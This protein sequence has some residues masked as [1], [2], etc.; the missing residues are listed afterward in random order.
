MSNDIKIVRLSRTSRD[1]DRFLQVSYTI[2]R[3]DPL[4]VAPLLMDLKKVF[5]DENPLFRH[6]SMELWVATRDGRDVG[7]IAGVIAETPQ[8]RL[9]IVADLVVGCD[10]R[11]SL[12]RE[13]ARLPLIEFGVPIDVLWMRLSKSPDDSTTTLGRIAAGR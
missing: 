7:R 8:G 13:Q 3:D 5:T 9:E 11:H 12:V 1:I 4:W 10:G 2:Y 6:A